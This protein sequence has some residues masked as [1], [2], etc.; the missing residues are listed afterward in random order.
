MTLWTGPKHSGKTSAAGDL[1]RRA[2]GAGSSV[3]GILAEA[4][5]ERGRRI[6]YDLVD[7][8][9]GAR[10]PL[11]RRG[12]RGPEAVGAF[13]FSE[14][15]LAAGAQALRAA[16]GADLAIVDE[17]GP[18][19]LAGGGWRQGVDALIGSADGLVLLVVR[20]RLVSKVRDL[21]PGV[22]PTVVEAAAPG[23]A[24]TVLGLL[25]P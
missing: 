18:L 21:W 6:G 13:T 10:V 15:G 4:V 11:A 1:A 2:G 5:H 12:G 22:E 25:R 7:L 14:A 17:F 9:T 8:R 23:A 16:A 3:A 19:E 24:E 20:E